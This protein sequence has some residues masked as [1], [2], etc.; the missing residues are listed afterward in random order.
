MHPRVKRTVTKAFTILTSSAAAAAS[1]DD[2]GRRNFGTFIAN[3]LRNYL[4][5]TWNKVQNEISHII[6]AADQELFDVSSPV[7]TPSSASQVSSPTNPYSAAGSEDV[8][9]S[10]LMCF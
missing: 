1:E 7:S 9:L 6:F 5:R 10:D 4:P 2:D 3:K 8:I